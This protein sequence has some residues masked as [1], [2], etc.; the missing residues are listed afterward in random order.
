MK[1]SRAFTTGAKQ[2]EWASYAEETQTLN[3]F[4]GNVFK[5]SVRERV[6]GR[7][8]IYHTIL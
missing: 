2:G 4:Q 5:D 8:M 6:T 1:D 7:V 3:G